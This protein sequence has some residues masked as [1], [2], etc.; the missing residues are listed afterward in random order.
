MKVINNISTVLFAGIV[1]ILTALC[2]A[3]IAGWEASEYFAYSFFIAWGLLFLVEII[4]VR[5][6]FAFFLAGLAIGAFGLYLSLLDPLVL[7]AKTQ[8]ALL[9]G[10]ISLTVFTA[11][12]AY[13][14]FKNK[15]ELE[16]NSTLF[17]VLLGLLVFQIL[18]SN[19][20]EVE[21]LSIGGFVNYFTVGVIFNILLNG[22][23]SK[24]L[25]KGEK[26]VLL[27]IAVSSLYAIAIML[28]A[29]FS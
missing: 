20:K 25:K 11:L 2:I 23:L 28:I 24:F 1:A 10:K 12:L 9:L 21:A 17:L 15:G 7:E 8:A 4:K 19:V 16:G 18:I 26:S 22:H 5:N 3:V 14:L 29:N 13:R 6:Y 27:M